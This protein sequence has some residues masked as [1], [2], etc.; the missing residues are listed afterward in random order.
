[1]GTE[2]KWM[3]KMFYSF[4]DLFESRSPVGDITWKS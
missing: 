2:E 4:R 1:M 3:D